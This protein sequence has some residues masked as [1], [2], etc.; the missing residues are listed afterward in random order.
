LLVIPPVWEPNLYLGGLVLLLGAAA[1]VIVIL[2]EP[3][4]V[5]HSASVAPSS[6]PATIE[7]TRMIGMEQQIRVDEDH[8]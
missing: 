8:R 1:I 5:R 2:L 6:S 4:G 3:K 7:S